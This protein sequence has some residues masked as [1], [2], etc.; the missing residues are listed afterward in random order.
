MKN[1][2]PFENILYIRDRKLNWK[3]SPTFSPMTNQFFKRGR[4][5]RPF[6]FERSKYQE[7][8]NLFKFK[9]HPRS[10]LLV[11]LDYHG[12]M[13]HKMLT[14]N[15]NSEVGSLPIHENIKI[16]FLFYPKF[17]TSLLKTKRIL[18]YALL[19]LLNL[20]YG[21]FIRTRKIRN[22]NL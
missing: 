19:D 9:I 12:S 16:C 1:N 8:I 22:C 17:S 6:F 18:M 3:R 7:P 5:N 10:S 15:G 20:Y 14:S 11:W 13:K 21:Y 4:W 2:P